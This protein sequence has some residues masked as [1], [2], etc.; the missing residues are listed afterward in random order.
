MTHRFYGELAAWWPLISPLDEYTEEAAFAATLLSSASVPV[1]EVLELGSGGGH[2][3]VHLKKSF[4]M[5]LTDLSEEMLDVSRRLNPECDH[6]CGD[7]RTLRLSRSFDAVF[8]H[9]SVDY[10]TNEVDL[11]RAIQTAFVHCRPGG[12][13]VFVPDA[14]T[15]TFQPASGHGGR[16]GADGRGVRYLDWSWDPDPEDSWTLTEYAFLLRDVDGSV[17]V[18][19]ETHRVGLFGG[20]DWLRFVGDAGFH[21]SAVTEVTSEDRTPRQFFVGHR[22]PSGPD[23]TDEYG[24]AGSS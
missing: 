12:V 2:N 9:D 24:A 23:T 4:A 15:E 11:R 3:A 6:H 16:D 22:P 17:R 5:T 19:H 7:M 8:V 21:A 10:M 13:A 14:T 1:S 18:V 20:E